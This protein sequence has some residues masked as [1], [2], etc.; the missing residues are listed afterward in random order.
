MMIEHLEGSKGI[1]RLLI[2]LL[3]Y[4]ET[5]VKRIMDGTDLYDRIINQSVSK[6]SELG[7]INARVDK[8]KYPYKRMISL[9]ERGKQV[10]TKLEEIDSLLYNH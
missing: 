10:A 1:M 5:N 7:L 3:N 9:T 8:T 6:L 4:K 2:Y